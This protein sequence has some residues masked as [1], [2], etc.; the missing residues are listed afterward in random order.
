MK[1]TV[2]FIIAV[3]M[4]F[5]CTYAAE[6]SGISVTSELDGVITEENGKKI[7]TAKLTNF[8]KE[9]LGYTM[10][11]AGYNANGGITDVAVKDKTAAD[12]RTETDR[13]E[14]EVSSD[15]VKVKAMVWKNL[16]TIVPVYGIFE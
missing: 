5:T 12:G 1:K 14:I 3:L 16:G 9:S 7:F 10:I 8:N 2:L 6:I 15:T 4:L 11:L 13:I